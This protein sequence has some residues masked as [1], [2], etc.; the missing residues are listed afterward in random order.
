[1]LLSLKTE[2]GPLYIQGVTNQLPNQ[3]PFVYIISS[4]V[5]WTEPVT[6][7]SQQ[8]IAKVK[9]CHSLDQI[10]IYNK[11]FLFSPRP[12]D[13]SILY[14]TSQLAEKSLFALTLSQCFSGIP[15]LFNEELPVFFQSVGFD[16]WTDQ[17]VKYQ[18]HSIFWQRIPLG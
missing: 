4:S 7:S 3:L 6:C 15:Y 9:G 12:K 10:M 11:E 2:E 18:F 1:M 17:E 13:R 16:C 8:N 5:V 14:H